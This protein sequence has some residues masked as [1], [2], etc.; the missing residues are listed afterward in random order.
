MPGTLSRIFSL[1]TVRFLFRTFSLFFPGIIFILLSAFTFW[2]LVAGRDVLLAALETKWA[3]LGF[4]LALC[5]WSYVSWFTSRLVSGLKQQQRKNDAT[6]YLPQGLFDQTPRFIGF[7]CFTIVWIGILLNLFEESS[8]F[9]A[10]N[11][12]LIFTITIVLGLIAFL[13]LN[14]LFRAICKPLN[15]SQATGLLIRSTLAVVIM[16]VVSAFLFIFWGEKNKVI[17]YDLRAWIMILTIVCMKLFFVLFVNLRRRLITLDMDKSDIEKRAAQPIAKVVEKNKHVKSF[18]ANAPIDISEEEFYIIFHFLFVVAFILYTICIFQVKIA[19]WFGPVSF[20]FLAFSIILGVGNWLSKKSLENK[21]SFHAICFLAAFLF[22]LVKKDPH[23]VQL[24]KKKADNDFSFHKRATLEEYFTNWLKVRQARLE[25]DSLFPVYI[26]MSDGGASRSGY[27]TASVL[28]YLQ[29]T[30]QGEF[31]Q[32]LFCLSGASGG[33]VG[34]TAFYYLLHHQ[35][36][37]T[38]FKQYLPVAKNY[39]RGDFLTFTLAR[40][41]STDIYQQLIP[42]TLV[43]DRAHALTRA[44]EHASKEPLLNTGMRATF[45]E[46]ANPDSMHRFQMPILFINTT[47]MQDAQPGVISTIRIDSATFNNRVD[48]LSELKA[49]EDMKL[50][51]AVV[52]G[53]RFPYISPAGRIGNQYFVDGGY[54]DNSGAGVVNETLIALSRLMEKSTDPFLVKYGKKV[55]FQVIHITNDPPPARDNLKRVNPLINDLAAPLQTLIGSYGAQTSINDLRLEN[56]IKMYMPDSTGYYDINLYNS[57][58][59]ETY[60]L[61]WFISKQTLARMDAR[62]VETGSPLNRLLLPE[63]KALLK[64]K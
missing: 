63:M 22:G 10:E 59:K 62:L 32:Q 40:L 64:L 5:F 29:D 35:H 61:N 33:S 20:I 43:P 26:V 31:G 23:I 55:R 24:S 21:V 44:L 7:S 1:N 4:M 45:S 58:R 27:W 14:R 50:S 30:T 2:N 51:T 11:F 47:R 46:M 3:Y 8:E 12:F 6:P 34:N 13:Y 57:Q 54:F 38:A 39:L 48:V 41:L 17:N 25:R 18:I 9:I 49:N 53:A 36:N 42:F 52:L 19:N 56:F 28:S 15:K 60:S 37:D 16:V